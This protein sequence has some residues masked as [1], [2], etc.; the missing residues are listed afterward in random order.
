MAI[1][2]AEVADKA[3]VADAQLLDGGAVDHQI[4]EAPSGEA[5]AAPQVQVG[6][7]RAVGHSRLFIFQHEAVRHVQVADGDLFAVQ[8]GQFNGGLAGQAD[9]GHLGAS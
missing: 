9:A 3:A 5:D 1:S 6:Q 8:V 7:L 4:A 2:Q